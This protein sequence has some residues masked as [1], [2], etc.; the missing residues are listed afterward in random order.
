MITG[1]DEKRVTFARLIGLKNFNEQTYKNK[2]L[3]IINH[4]KIPI[5]LK[6]QDDVYEVMIDKGDM[7]LGDLRNYA[8]DLVPINEILSIFDDDDWRKPDYIEFMVSKL[9]ETKSIAVFMKNRMEYNLANGFTF[10]SRFRDGNTHIMCIK[11]D[12]LRYTSLDT[13]EDVLLKQDLYSFKKKYIAID[14]DP[15]MYIRIIHQNNTSPYA[16]DN[17]TATIKYP[18]G[19]NYQEYDAKEE[20]KK[21]VAGIIKQYYGFFL[22]NK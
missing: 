22:Y 4:G 12:R 2:R 1:K 11:L 20:E 5:M 17:R 19:G 3:I 6:P 14:N 9:L 7:T 8:L 15:T 16:K 13:L 18:V 10:T 21:Y